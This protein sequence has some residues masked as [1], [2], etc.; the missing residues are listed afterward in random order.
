MVL[1]ITNDNKIDQGCHSV[2]MFVKMQC[3]CLNVDTT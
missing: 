1:H 3:V 2:Q